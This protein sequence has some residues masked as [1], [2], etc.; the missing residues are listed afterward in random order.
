[1]EKQQKAY[2]GVIDYFKQK[3]I[4][5][6]TSSRGKAAAGAGYRRTVGCKPQFSTGGNPYHGYDGG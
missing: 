5:G 6:E 1:M 4:D 2:K 3:I